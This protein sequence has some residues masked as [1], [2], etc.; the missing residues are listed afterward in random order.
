MYIYI[1][2]KEKDPDAHAVYVKWQDYKKT[3]RPR[4]LDDENNGYPRYTL[5]K[6]PLGLL[7]AWAQDICQEFNLNLWQVLL[8]APSSFCFFF[9]HSVMSI[10]HSVMSIVHS[11]Y[12]LYI[13]LCTS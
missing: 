7:I 13:L 12:P 1:G 5:H 10:V 4:I 2:T 3:W 8:H 6:M 9:V 11:V